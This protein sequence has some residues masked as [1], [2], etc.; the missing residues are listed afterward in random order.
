MAIQIVA[1]KR[2]KP[3]SERITRYK[4][5]R[6]EGVSET[7]YRA[8]LAMVGD[9]ELEPFKDLATIDEMVG[10][11]LTKH[12]IYGRRRAAYLSFAR[13]LYKFARRYGRVTPEYTAAMVSKYVFL[14]ECRREVLEEIA[15]EVFG[16]GVAAGA[17]GAITL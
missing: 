2:P 12:G 10:S 6:D 7:N 14:E 17:G 13:E 9:A 16:V 1:T 5:M 8:K 3:A 11:I 4:R 15:S